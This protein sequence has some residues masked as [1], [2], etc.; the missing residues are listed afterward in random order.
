MFFEN[1]DN[2]L[3]STPLFVQTNLR[4]KSIFTA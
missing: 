4:D 2:A 3:V 1:L